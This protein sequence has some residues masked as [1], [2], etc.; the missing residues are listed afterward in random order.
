M[1]IVVKEW[2][3]VVLLRDGRIDRVLDAGAHRVRGR[4]TELLRVDLRE[5]Q[6]V[7]SSQEILTEDRVAVKV[8]A[9]VVWRV[10]DPTAFLTLAEAPLS[11]LHTAVQ[12][13]L[14]ARVA[15]LALDALLADREALA[16]GVADEVQA[17]VQSLGV[18]IASVALRDVMLPAEVRRAV[19][20]VLLAREQGRAELER[21]RAEA[22][23]LRSLANTARLL[24]EHPALLHLRTLQA[25]G[26]GTTLV[27]APPGLAVGG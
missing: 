16:R 20:Q 27:V 2:E 18:S 7:L 23:A 5:R 22:A 12:Q 10:V 21:A 26:P 4:R 25:A 6:H 11:R 9:V 19:T 8:S 1:R 24:E 17:E 15:A 14:R 13:A 3:R